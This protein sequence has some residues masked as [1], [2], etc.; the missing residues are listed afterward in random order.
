M[1][2]FACAVAMFLPTQN[3]NVSVSVQISTLPF[4]NSFV[5]LS[6]LYNHTHDVC[7]HN[8]CMG[9]NAALLPC[10]IETQTEIPVFLLL[11]EVDCNFEAQPCG[12]H[13]LTKAMQVP[14]GLFKVMEKILKLLYSECLKPCC[15]LSSNGI[16]HRFPNSLASLLA[17]VWISWLPVKQ[18]NLLIYWPAEC[19][20]KMLSFK[21]KDR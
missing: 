17:F 15:F 13:V 7:L 16:C 18:F 5:H 12:C 1:L 19:F 6:W 8:S 2:L 14:H 11:W 10:N 9:I 3:A 4:Q 20:V 21:N